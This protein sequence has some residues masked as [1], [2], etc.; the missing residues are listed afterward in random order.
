MASLVGLEAVVVMDRDVV[1][2]MYL[3]PGGYEIVL[4]G[5]EV[6][7]DFNG[8]GVDC[9]GGDAIS[10]TGFWGVDEKAFPGVGKVLTKDALSRAKFSEF[11]VFTGDEEGEP[12][13][14]P[15]R[16]GFLRFDFDDGSSLEADADVLASATA[17][18][19]G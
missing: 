7:F 19:A 6:A 1:E 16:V 5:K 11:Y 9:L 14:H 3:S 10:I 12:E 4:D 15:K 2:E 13:I 8:S 17:A 18:L